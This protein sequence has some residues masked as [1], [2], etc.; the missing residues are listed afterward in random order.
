MNFSHSVGL[1]ENSIRKKV[2]Y[3]DILIQVEPDLYESTE[4]M[5][6]ADILRSVFQ[7]FDDVCESH[8]VS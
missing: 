3:P 2:Q 5:K 7:C 4:M 1:A 8:S 6:I